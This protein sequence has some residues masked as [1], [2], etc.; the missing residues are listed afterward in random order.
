[1]SMMRMPVF[2]WMTLVVQFLVILAFP[3]IGVALLYLMFD[4]IFGTGFFVVA[5]GGDPL[6]WQHLFWLF[7][8]PEVYI[9]ILPAMGIVSEILP[10]FSRKPLFGAAFIIFSGI[11]I[12]FLGFGV[13]AHHMFAAGMGPVADTAFAITTMM[14]AI[15]TGVKVFNWIATI[16]GGH[17]VLKTPM[18]FALGFVALFTVGGLSGVM[19]ASPPIDLQQT[20]TYFVVAHIHYVLFGGAMMGLFG[21]IYYWF[22][23]VTGRMMSEK[24]GKWHFWLTFLSMNMTFFP[25]HYL[26]VH[27]MPR[28]IYTYDSGLGFEL[29]NLVATL[30]SF[31]LGLATLL[32]VYNLIVSARSGEKAGND[33]WDAGTLEWAIPSPP[34]EYNFAQ[35]PLVTSS[36]PLWDAKYG[37]Q[38]TDP[39]LDVTVAGKHIA[40]IDLRTHVNQ[41]TEEAIHMPNPSYWPILLAVGPVIMATGVMTLKWLIPVGAVWMFYCAF[42]W[43]F[44]PAE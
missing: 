14:I 39:T 8:H 35:L 2:V 24:L 15:P 43:A 11:A 32:F 13:W 28:R 19:H 29:W 23:K 38:T 27:G 26:G 17:L 44:E 31:A 3:I 30:G 22:P 4:R 12:G 40:D 6:L 21:G 34:P 1:M 10:T 20:D 9:L 18:Y 7:G 25:M 16:W 36:R 42:R 33:P 37:V 41:M 5:Q